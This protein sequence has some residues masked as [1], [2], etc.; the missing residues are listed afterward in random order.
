MDWPWQTPDGEI[1]EREGTFSFV[2]NP[3]RSMVYAYGHNYINGKD[4]G[5]PNR[6]E[7]IY[8]GGK[9]R[10][11]S[12]A[13]WVTEIPAEIEPPPEAQ[14]GT[15][16]TPWRNLWI[17]RQPDGMYVV[18]GLTGTTTI[19]SSG[20]NQTVQYT[21][22]VAHTLSSGGALIRS[23]ETSAPFS[24]LS[25]ISSSFAGTV[26]YLETVTKL[27]SYEYNDTFF[28]ANIA[29]DGWL[30]SEVVKTT[31]D[32]ESYT[33]P[34]YLWAQWYDDQGHGLV[35]DPADPPN[36]SYGN[37]SEWYVWSPDGSRAW[38]SR[39]WD[40]RDKTTT[41]L[42]AYG[43][44]GSYHSYVDTGD[45]TAGFALPGGNIMFVA[46]VTHDWNGLV[47]DGQDHSFWTIYEFSREP[48][49][50]NWGDSWGGDWVP[51]YG[52]AAG[53]TEFVILYPELVDDRIVIVNPQD[54][55]DPWVWGDLPP[56]ADPNGFLAWWLDGDVIRISYDG[57]MVLAWQ[58]PAD[59][60][61]LWESQGAVPGYYNTQS[62]TFYTEPQPAM[63][64]AEW[65]QSPL[66]LGST[67]Y[68]VDTTTWE[69]E[70]GDNLTEH[71]IRWRGYDILLF[72]DRAE[73]GELF[74]DQYIQS[75][76]RA[77]RFGYKT[78]P[79]IVDRQEAQMIFD[80][81][82]GWACYPVEAGG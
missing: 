32:V 15:F 27:R 71:G 48:G 35:F 70:S 2:V 44:Y 37:D 69:S 81:G 58:I 75:A 17:Y 74:Q 13:G 1:A 68:R 30:P 6:Y 63:G 45:G 7:Y 3:D 78:E 19:D 12:D 41:K 26:E 28:E 10:V 42:P 29:I 18:A 73:G 21:K 4:W 61:A 38:Q 60:Y 53:Q 23:Y 72:D 51:A 55:T 80:A 40:G 57:I 59:Y 82:F 43:P 46:K 34:S 22:F 33:S 14:S 76:K 50:W 49:P 64:I 56:G 24:N 77:Y 9:I 39:V 25:K 5:E 31:A 65:T 52:Y 8:I 67:T 16:Q 11:W 20:S 54:P 62:K 79:F 47:G 66:P 36:S